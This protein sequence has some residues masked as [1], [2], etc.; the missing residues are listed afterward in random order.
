M[1]AS[2]VGMPKAGKSC[3]R[4]IA[5][6][7]SA[8]ARR[9]DRDWSDRER[10]EVAQ[11]PTPRRA[12]EESSD[13]ARLRTR[14]FFGGPPA[15]DPCL[16]VIERNREAG[17]VKIVVATAGL[18]RHPAREGDKPNEERPRRNQPGR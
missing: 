13:L 5:V 7:I 15:C 6:Q 3:N 2:S 8:I 12:R 4:S 14:Q 18:P 16:D 9:A 10:F 11:R 1:S 17:P